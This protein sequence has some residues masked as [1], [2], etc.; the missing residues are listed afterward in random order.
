M[1]LSVATFNAQCKD[2]KISGFVACSSF[3]DL[4]TLSYSLD[5]SF[6]EN[7]LYAVHENFD[8]FPWKLLQSYFNNL[9][10]A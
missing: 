10:I 5:K 1:F 6:A 9:K 2:E 4:K 8:Q 3:H 7:S